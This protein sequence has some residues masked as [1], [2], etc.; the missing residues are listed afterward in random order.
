[1]MLDIIE[2]LENLSPRVGKR[3]KEAAELI[4]EELAGLELEEQKFKNEVPVGKAELFID[5]RQMNCL[6]SSFVSGSIEEKS[7]ISSVHVSARYYSES[8]INFNPYSSS[9]SLATFYF[10]P[11]VAVEKET[12]KAIVDGEEVKG[13]VWVRR[14][15]F[16]AE[17]ILVGNIKNP[18]T[19]CFAHYDSVLNGAIDNASG[20]AIMLE[21]IKNNPELLDENLFVF[22]G[23]EELSYDKPIYWGKGYRMFEEEFNSLLKNAKK[24]V[25]VDS[26]GFADPV[27][28]DSFLLSAIPLRNLEELKHKTRILFG[29]PERIRNLWEIYHTEQDVPQ[30]IRMEYLQS[31][32]HMLIDFL[33]K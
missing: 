1:M 29:N 9:I 31:A 23:S 14:E 18:R 17:N 28:T 7:V 22:S 16:V 11:S 10:A 15:P 5:G 6:A 21:V 33:R 25:C 26:V 2:R 27:I 20:V 8:N 24:L 13:K 19:V 12:I 30:V 32:Y 4:K 3:E